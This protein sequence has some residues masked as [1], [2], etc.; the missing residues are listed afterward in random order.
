M[1]D[2][3]PPLAHAVKNGHGEVVRALLEGEPPT[4]E[5]AALV[6][7]GLLQASHTSAA[8]RR[9][10]N[11]MKAS[12]PAAYFHLV[13]FDAPATEPRA[14]AP[15]PVSALGPSVLPFPSSRWAPVRSSLA[16]SGASTRPLGR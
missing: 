12:D 2:G 6:I 5:R 7:S 16:R 8:T 15:P 11:A 1:Q 3:T 13:T 10:L 14:T 9:A 4:M